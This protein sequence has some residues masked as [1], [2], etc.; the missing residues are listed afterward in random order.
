MTTI[1]KVTAAREP[2]RRP[3][4]PVGSLRFDTMFV[5]LSALF[6]A[7]LYLDGWA[8]NT[9]PGL[10]E[11]FFTPYHAVLYGGFTA[12]AALLVVTAW[13]NV[14]AGY[15]LH[16][17][18]PRPYLPAVF[19]IILFTAG[20][21][22]DM[23]WH[24]A[25]G[26][27]K[28]VEALLSPTHL[29]LA[30]GGLLLGIGP[31]RA[32]WERPS[33][34]PTGR[35]L[36]PAILATLLL[37]STFTFFTQYTHL[38]RT[39][40]LTETP[41]DGLQ[42]YL[43]S[44]VAIYAQ[45]M[46]LLLLTGALLFLMRRWR[47]PTGTVTFLVLGN[48]LAMYLMT[49]IDSFATPATLAAALAGGLAGDALYVWLAPAPERPSRL[50]LFAFLLPFLL[51]ALHLLAVGLTAGLWWAIHMWAGV[52]FLLGALGLLLGFLDAPPAAPAHDH[53]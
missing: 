30:S 7:G 52:P 49:Q 20:G 33:T 27:E 14:R 17:A 16:R 42:G 36:F 44:V 35:E 8:H 15:S 40:T 18:L 34:R 47:L 6:G 24:N 12:V 22:T 32:A 13:Q 39:W 23:L 3:D 28:D 51:S 26:F 37:L 21:V 11:T 2:A 31:L 48:Y 29:L 25:F 19:G 4:F 45:V 41:P 9:M 43:Y 38:A 46:P 53:P 10:I 1:D 50:R 5:L